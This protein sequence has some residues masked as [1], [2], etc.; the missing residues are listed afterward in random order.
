MRLQRRKIVLPLVVA[1]F[2]ASLSFMSSSAAAGQ[3]S[4]EVEGFTKPVIF[5]TDA[6]IERAKARVASQQ[7]PFYGS[8]LKTKA[9]A[10]AALTKTY[11]PEQK[12]NHED[13]FN[14]GKAHGQDVRS[15]ALVYRITGET[16]YADKARQIIRL[17][18]EDALAGP[19]PSEGSH[20]SAGLVIG[21]VIPIFADG[22]AM[23]WDVSTEEEKQLVRDWFE[24]MIFP[25]K[26]S[27]DIWQTGTELCDYGKPCTPFDPP[28]LNNQYYNNHLGAQNMGLMAIGL[29]MNDQ[30]L[31][32]EAMKHPHNKRNL[33]ELI[34]G[35]ILMP[36]DPLYR[37]DPTV[38]QGA[39]EAQAGEIYDRYRTGEGKGLHYSHIHLRFLVLQADMLKNNERGRD[40]FRYVGR[41]GENLELP[42]TF[43]SEF[44]QTGS[45]EARTGYY[46]KSTVDY[47][48]LPLFEIAHREYP[49]NAEVRNVLESFDRVAMDAETF[50]WTLLLTDGEDGLAISSE[51]Y[52][53]RSLS[54]WGFDLDGNFQGWSVRKVPS[55]VSGGAL[56]M[57]VDRRDPGMVSPDLLGLPTTEYSKVEVRMRNRTNDTS[58]QLFYITD[59]D[60]VFNEAKSVTIPISSNDAV[61]QTYVID[62]SGLP[63]WTGRVR[64]IRIDPVLGVS[65]GQVSVDSVRILP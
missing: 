38:T 55:T 17:W 61:Y 54:S 3:G 40:W 46:W 27:R 59:A 33:E 26:R 6:E 52:P 36:G 2:A 15:L 18:A 34:N 39:P 48:L 63:G 12:Y 9:A 44:L 13:Y 35:V 4:E 29:A 56:H 62:M 5:T 49:A 50:G 7:E 37:N 31:V 43:Y 47:G 53:S 22:H 16:K 64:Q 8:W 51:P 24:K 21:R 28:Y 11:V 32:Q 57:D 23:L 30:R 58:F 20:H 65:F 1:L 14:L 25:I 60:T 19:Y 41:N 45:S 10:D 42:F